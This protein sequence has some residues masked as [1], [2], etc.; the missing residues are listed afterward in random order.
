MIILEWVIGIAI[1]TG[2]FLF[3]Y[4]SSVIVYERKTGKPY[5]MFWEKKQEDKN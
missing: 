1:L 2:L 3:A 4:V 5:R